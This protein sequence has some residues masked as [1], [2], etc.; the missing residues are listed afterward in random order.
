MADGCSN[1]LASFL[2]S[3]ILMAAQ[4]QRQRPP[5]V[6]EV[7]NDV[8]NGDDPQLA[9]AQPGQDEPVSTP[10]VLQD[11]SSNSQSGRSG[12]VANNTHHGD[13]PEVAH[14]QP[15]QDEPVS[16]SKGNIGRTGAN[17]T[18]TSEVPSLFKTA[19]GALDKAWIQVCE[20]IRPDERT[21][22]YCPTPMDQNGQLSQVLKA[23]DDANDVHHGDDPFDGSAYDGPFSRKDPPTPSTSPR[24]RPQDM[25]S[26]ESPQSTQQSTADEQG[27]ECKTNAQN[28]SGASVRESAGGEGPTKKEHYSAMVCG[29]PECTMVM[30]E[31]KGLCTYLV[32]SK[33]RR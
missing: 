31:H 22:D 14:A 21:R 5:L 29:N 15:G 12:E 33:R 7:A 24:V 13:D 2:V 1:P 28:A 23:G 18:E 19:R 11:V 26:H 25:T 6:L 27:G 32:S 10:N 16:T 17:T 8:H 20:D 9:H 3:Q 30:T 4:L